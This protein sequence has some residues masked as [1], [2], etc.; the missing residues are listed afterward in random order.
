MVTNNI[1][2]FV[3]LNLLFRYPQCEADLLD[4]TSDEKIMFIS[5]FIF[6]EE[7]DGI[8]CFNSVI[9]RKTGMKKTKQFVMVDNIQQK[10]PIVDE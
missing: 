5:D 3:L 2:L 8:N 7:E 4:S 1:S 10:F 9:N 6:T